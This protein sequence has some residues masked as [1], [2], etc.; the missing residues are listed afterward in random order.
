MIFSIDTKA[1]HFRSTFENIVLK[2][3]CQ[4]YRKTVPRYRIKTMQRWKIRQNDKKKK[5]ST[6]SSAALAHTS[7]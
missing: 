7:K 2:N 4:I 3:A 5:K 6:H 1:K